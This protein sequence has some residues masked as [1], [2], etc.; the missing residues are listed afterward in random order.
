M[1][2]LKSLAIGFLGIS[3][4]LSSCTQPKIE[5]DVKTEIDSMSYA[6]GINM[7]A[8]FKQGDIDD[9]N[10]MAFAKGFQ[11]SY[12]GK[13]NAMT[14]EK[15]IEFLN[16]YFAKVNEMKM[17]EAIEEGQKFLEE[18]AKQEGVIV[19]STGLQYKVITEGTGPMP[20]AEDMVKVH[21]RGTLIDGTEFDSSLEKEPAQFKL[22]RVIRGWTIGLQ[23][24]KVG[25]KYMLYIPSDLG[26]GPR[27]PAGGPIK[28]NSVLIFEVEL[29]E[30]VKEAKK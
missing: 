30:I 25:S 24:M 12:E 15:A 8:R 1:K 16:K 28:P 17:R 22:N 20:T 21:Y 11:E 2:I 7:A 4:L 13:E 14:N 26:Y 5:A 19:D 3:V 6:L 29:L 9:I 18:N 10:I 27:P 23:K